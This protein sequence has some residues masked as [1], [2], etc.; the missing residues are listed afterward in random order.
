MKT[1]QKHIIACSLALLSL[2]ATAQK[3][4]P[5]VLSDTQ[6]MLRVPTAMKYL[7][8]PVEESANND[9]IRVIY[10]NNVVRELNVRLAVNKADYYVPLPLQ[11]EH[12]G[13]LLLDITMN[14]GDAANS[15]SK[16]AT[17]DFACWKLLQLSDTFNMKNREKFRPV[18]DHTPAYGW[19]NDPNGMFYKDG[20]WNL[21]YQHNPFGS[22][23]ENMT[24]GHSTSTDLIHWKFEGDAVLP[25]ALG[26]ISAA[27]QWWTRIIRPASAQVLSY[28]TIPLPEERRSRTWL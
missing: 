10:N 6:V 11:E 22:Q 5:Q 25:D 3:L 27:A 2:S 26:T 7:L 28:L 21:Y 4:A 9:H 17:G 18:Y 23:W 8:L 14:R 12:K 20:V 1:I 16:A 24:W 15:A 13:N 19:M